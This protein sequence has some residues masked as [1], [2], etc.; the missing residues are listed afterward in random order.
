MTTNILVMKDSLYTRLRQKCR[1]ENYQIFLQISK[2][3][4]MKI[5]YLQYDGRC[6]WLEKQ[7]LNKLFPELIREGATGKVNKYI[8]LD[9]ISN[10]NGKVGI[11]IEWFKK[12]KYL[13]SEL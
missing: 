8:I 12:N 13:T 6:K 9:W 5:L 3:N 2:T 7:V 10:D 1:Q 11:D 4:N